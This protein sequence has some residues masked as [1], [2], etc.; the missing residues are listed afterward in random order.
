[1]GANRIFAD[2]STLLDRVG[3]ETRRRLIGEAAKI[4]MPPDELILARAVLFL[5]QTR[6]SSCRSSGTIAGRLTRGRRT[7]GGSPS[8]SLTAFGKKSRLV[9]RNAADPFVAE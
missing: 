1:M 5:E 7:S 8:G 4:G 6:P 3:S 9:A 2:H